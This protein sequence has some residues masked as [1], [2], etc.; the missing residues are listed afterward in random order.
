MPW[1][2]ERMMKLYAYK[3]SKTILPRPNNIPDEVWA[4]SLMCM[5]SDPLQR[6]KSS[7]AVE[8]LKT[9]IDRGIDWT[10]NV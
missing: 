6:I 5:D 3:Q 7:K 9:F 2:G 4:F 1:Q 8:M 10:S